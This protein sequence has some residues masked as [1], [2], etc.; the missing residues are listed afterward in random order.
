M[1]DGIFPSAV[2]PSG[3]DNGTR[4]HALG[5]KDMIKKV[6]VYRRIFA[7]DDF[8]DNAKCKYARY[9]F[10]EDEHAIPIC[11][12]GDEIVLRIKTGVAYKRTDNCI[13]A[14]KRFEAER[15]QES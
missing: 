7:N 8:C 4:V 11:T 14:Q 10:D 6:L 12:L 9:L 15:D 2:F 13:N 1:D 5:G 3:A